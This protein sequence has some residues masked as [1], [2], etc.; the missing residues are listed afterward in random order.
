[1]TRRARGPGSRVRGPGSRARGPGRRVGIG[2]DTGGTF[3]K[4]VSV[5]PQGRLLRELQ[6]PTLPEDGPRSFVRRVAEAVRREQAALGARAAG[7]GLAIAGDVDSERGT[8][9][10]S[11]NLRS[12]DGYPLRAALSGAARRRVLIEN[13]ANMAAWGGYVVELERKARNVLVVAMGTGVGGGLVLE[14][15]LF[16]GSTGSAGEIGHASVD[17]R[18]PRCACGV[19]G[20]VEA[21]A[22]SYGIVRIARQMLRGRASALRRAC[23]DLALLEPRHV[24]LAAS[25]GDA[26]ARAV[27]REAGRKLGLAI[28]DAVYLFNP[29]VVLIAG[30]V[31]RAG[32]LILDPVLELLRE[33][34]F[35]TPFE[36]ARVRIARTPNLGAIGAGLLALE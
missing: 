10:F 36:A 18:G 13:D 23:P 5:T 16:H 9:R 7:L 22:G 4:I 32:R 3:T 19:R 21:Y 35:K 14:G 27:W 28:A 26:V 2:I 24:A 1:M 30:G 34:P 25:K 11:P 12:F 31:S 29:D 17:P 33:Q 6:L 15:K 8:V 20:H